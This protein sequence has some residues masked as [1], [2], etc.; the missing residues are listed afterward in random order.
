MKQCFWCGSLV[1]I[2]LCSASLN[3]TAAAPAKAGRTSAR[4]TPKPPALTRGN[5]VSIEFQTSGGIANLQEKLSIRP[6]QISQTRVRKA[7]PFGLAGNGSS[8]SPSRSLTTTSTLSSKQLEAL[9]HTL[10]A[11]GFISLAGKYKQAQLRGG[12]H[13]TVT[14]RLRDE[15][16]V[17]RLFVIE[18]YGNTAPPGFFKVTAYLQQLKQ[19]KF[20]V[21]NQRGTTQNRTVP[22][23]SRDN[24]VSLEWASSSGAA[25]VR[26][27]FTFYSGL[28]H[29]KQSAILFVRPRI[30][31][32]VKGLQKDLL[33]G[34]LEE[35]C[36][37]LNNTAFAKLLG[38]H[39]RPYHAAGAN[40]AISF[41]L[42]DKDGR[43]E[44][45]AAGAYGDNA[46]PAFSVV[47]KELR[48]LTTRIIDRPD[49]N[50][51]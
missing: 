50:K 16:K 43:H 41:T 29:P 48:E 37:V 35:L 42:L 21:K 32:S 24:L 14:L 39:A 25:D 11:A 4:S 51:S 19:Q 38:T 13:E 22:R 15:K 46:P 40:E 17:D 1:G 23:A 47:M 9:I 2:L 18:N 8:D 36:R 26:T 27:T 10:N 5:F 20:A 28:S 34:D 3:I 12:I 7:A 30:S 33:P 45:F 6:N 31:G 49:P 44:V